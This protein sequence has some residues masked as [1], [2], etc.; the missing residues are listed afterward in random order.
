MSDGSLTAQ[1]AFRDMMR[2]EIAPAIRR[3]GFAGSGGN[4]RLVDGDDVAHVESQKSRWNSKDE[5][6]F[7]FNLWV[8][9]GRLSTRLGELLPERRDFWW[10]LGPETSVDELAGAV[11]R[12]L[13]DFG[14]PAIQAALEAPEPSPAITPAEPPLEIPEG[15]AEYTRRLL[16]LRDEP[17]VTA[18]DSSSWSSVPLDS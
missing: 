14:W 5:V 11:I 10:V 6:A 17:W 13:E 1:D 7:T 12:A 15:G 4:F 2:H 3:M 8:S 16:A 9:G 18:P